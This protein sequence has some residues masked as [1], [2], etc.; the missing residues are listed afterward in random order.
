MYA[1]KIDWIGGLN[2]VVLMRDGVEVASMTLDEWMGL[3]AVKYA[4]EEAT[5]SL[6]LA[7]AAARAAGSLNPG[8]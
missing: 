5:R 1:T 3:G 7:D 4:A 6:A 2:V 8:D